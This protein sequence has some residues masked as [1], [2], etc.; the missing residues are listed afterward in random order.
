[1]STLQGMIDQ[2]ERQLF[3]SEMLK[4]MMPGSLARCGD[5]Y[6]FQNFAWLAWK[7]RGALQGKCRGVTR[8]GCQYL[9]PCGG[10]C[11]KCGQQH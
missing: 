9:A 8:D 4:H 7:A 10:L 6:V 2:L 1:M 5:G 11:D 3:E